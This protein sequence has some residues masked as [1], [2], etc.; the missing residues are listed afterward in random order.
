[1]GGLK[2]EQTSDTAVDAATEPRPMGR[3]RRA[4]APKRKRVRKASL[5]RRTRR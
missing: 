1:M 5:R 3:L 4:S 2:Y